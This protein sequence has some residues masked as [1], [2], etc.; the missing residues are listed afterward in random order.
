MSNAPFQQRNRLAGQPFRGHDA[1]MAT[2]PPKHEIYEPEVLPPEAESN[3]SRRPPVAAV[4]RWRRLWQALLAGLILDGADL[5][6]R[7]P[8]IPQ[9]ALLGA[10]TGWYIVRTQSV[11]RA[12]RIWWI[13]ASAL[14][15]AMPMT[16]F[17]PL[18]TLFLVYRAL[19]LKPTNP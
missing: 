1:A 5:F 13:A 11:P 10:V 12:Q 7:M 19:T 2:D 15:C 3:T 18:A 16:E 8:M 17:Y 9:G 14:Y 4:V 6:T